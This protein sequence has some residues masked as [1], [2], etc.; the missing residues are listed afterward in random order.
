MVGDD[1]L[2]LQCDGPWLLERHLAE[3][4]V[5]LDRPL[6]GFQAR[7]ARTLVSRAMSSRIPPAES[8]ISR[9]RTDTLSSPCRSTCSPHGPE[10]ELL[11]DLAYGSRRRARGTSSIMQATWRRSPG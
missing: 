5:P 6:L 8:M 10:V 3:I 7:E 4:G 11:A 1:A 2:G 9:R